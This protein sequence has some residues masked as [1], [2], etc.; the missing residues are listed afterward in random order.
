MCTG[1]D[2]D[3]VWFRA[4]LQASSEVDR[5]TGG[6]RQFGIL[7]E[8]L[9]SLDA[10]SALDPELTDRRTD[11]E[12]RPE[13]S[14]GVVPVGERDSKRRHHRVARVRLDGAAVRLDAACDEL[15]ELGYAAASDLQIGCG[16]ESGR[17]DQI[18]EDNRCQL[19]FDSISMR[20]DAA[21]RSRLA[22]GV[23]GA[24][25]DGVVKMVYPPNSRVDAVRMWRCPHRLLALHQ[26]TAAVDPAAVRRLG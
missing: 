11:L 14:L 5:R 10:D 22:R 17:A 24:P 8:N 4:L 16:D 15:E 7:G 12:C 20:D 26:D 19:S 2:E 3:L 13:R 25:E 9:T 6:K 18:D 21:L 23:C 1:T